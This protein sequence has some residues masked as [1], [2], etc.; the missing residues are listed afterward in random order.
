MSR[1]AWRNAIFFSVP[2]WSIIIL[3]LLWLTGCRPF[4]GSTDP[5]NVEK[6]QHG[7]STLL[8]VRVAQHNGYDRIVF[9]FDSTHHDQ[10]NVF[11]GGVPSYHIGYPLIEVY[12]CGSGEPVFAGGTPFVVQFQPAQAHTVEG[13][14]T[15]GWRDQSFGFP[16]VRRAQVICDFEADVQFLFGIQGTHVFRVFELKGTMA[17]GPD[18]GERLVID[19]A[20]DY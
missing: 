3:G 9:E 11:E 7:I 19:I 14:P 8:D 13:K 17:L 15:L 10:D 5:V 4:K 16:A 12:Q 2:L 20:H 18:A 6:P 1:T